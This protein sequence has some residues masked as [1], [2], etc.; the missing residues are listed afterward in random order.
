[1]PAARRVSCAR[2]MRLAALAYGFA[3]TFKLRE[4][5]PAFAGA[6]LRKA[7]TQL[8][9]EYGEHAVAVAYDFGAVIFVN[10]GA[11]E[12]ARVIGTI[13]A[14]VARDEPHA[15][16]E[17]DFVVE[18]SP[19]AP[20]SGEVHFDRVVVPALSGHVVDIVTVLLAQ[21]VSIDYYEE[22]LQEIIS[23]LDARTDAMARHGKLI[24]SHREVMRFV[25]ASISTKNQIIAALAV[26]D[27]PAVTWENEALDKLHRDLRAMLEIDERFKAL[28]YKMRTIQDT[29]ELFLETMGTRRSHVLEAVIVLLIVLE[30]VLALARVV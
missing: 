3:T 1:M 16:L 11:E 12:R 23:K 30:I 28:E 17:E 6:R 26:L 21:S 14:T 15:P 25:G 10:V 7:K 20:P 9:A 18:V 2:P 19:S 22:D 24:G 29:L 27:K 13:L 5:A 8:V 4:V